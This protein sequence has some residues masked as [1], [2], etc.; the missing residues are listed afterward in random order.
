MNGACRLLGKLISKLLTFGRSD[1]HREEGRDVKQSSLSNGPSVD[2]LQWI[3]SKEG[4][5]ERG[6][7]VHIS[8]LD[9]VAEGAGGNVMKE[10][11][12]GCGG[13]L[14]RST[15][16]QACHAIHY[17]VLTANATPIVLFSAVELAQSFFYDE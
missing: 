6:V 4:I 3:K 14:S 8:Y 10:D 9:D 15:D 7:L 1:D 2:V 11:R 12:Q 13:S 17:G 5:L 16:L